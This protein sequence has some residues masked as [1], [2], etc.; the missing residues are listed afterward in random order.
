VDIAAA[1]AAVFARIAD[2]SSHARWR[3]T[4]LEFRAVDGEP[5]RVGS[6]LVE[7]VRFA[8]RRFRSTYEVSELDPPRAFAVRTVTGPMRLTLRCGLAPAGRGTRVTFT[9]AA[10]TSRLLR[11]VLRLFLWDEARRLK[12]LLEGP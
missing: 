10:E 9:L 3:P 6:R 1:P 2:P 7:T 11:T 5:L 8:G 12:R 4:V